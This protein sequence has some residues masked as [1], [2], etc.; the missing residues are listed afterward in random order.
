MRIA[1]DLDGQRM[2]R[3]IHGADDSTTLSDLLSKVGHES[4]S[5]RDVYVDDV[6]TETSTLLSD[7]TLLEGSLISYQPSSVEQSFSGWIAAVAG[8]LNTGAVIALPEHRRLL[9]GRSPHADIQLDTESASWEHAS[10]EVEDQSDSGLAVR[11]RDSKSTNGTFVNGEQVPADDEGILISQTAT[12]T[13]GGVSI[14]LRPDFAEQK[15]PKP[16]SLH[17]LT[18]A[19]TAPFNR[20]PRP[21]TVAD[22]PPLTPP[23]RKVV[24]PASKFSYITVIAPLLMAGAMVMMMGNARYAMFALLSPVMAIGMW[25]EQKRR[26][27]KNLAEEE[28]RFSQALDEFKEQMAEASKDEAERIREW[29]PDTSVVLRTGRFPTT[30][31]WQRRAQDDDVLTLNAGTGQSNWKPELAPGTNVSRMDKDIRDTY[32]ANKLL[33]APV[34]ADLS[35]AGVVGIVGER[36]GALALARSLVIQAAT[37]VGPADLRIAVFC[38]RGRADGWGFASW[39]PHTRRHGSSEH[40]QWL[41]DQSERSKALLKDL[42][43]ATD[44]Q[45][46]G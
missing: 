32:E 2:I 14:L 31:L 29:V 28:S 45:V 34:I 38:D 41:S 12:V 21:G 26:H 23:E 9:L 22:H 44:A 11:I 1:F 25:F 37:H 16:G 24:A 33:A 10:F 15:A 40:E 20:P 6:R 4:A 39:L 5:G 43:E 42:R 7:L 13:L 36:E 46:P 18:S 19:Q 8:G 3:D 30:R 27:K 35:N 17:N